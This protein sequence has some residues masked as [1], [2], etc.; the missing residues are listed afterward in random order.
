MKI[1]GQY[2]MEEIEKVFNSINDL[3]NYKIDSELY[4]YFLHDIYEKDFWNYVQNIDPKLCNEYRDLNSGDDSYEMMH[5]RQKAQQK[6]SEKFH[7]IRDKFY[8]VNG[9]IYSYKYIGEY[10]IGHVIEITEYE[11]KDVHYLLN[12]LA[13]DMNEQKNRNLLQRILNK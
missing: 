4:G 9:Q 6:Y 13:S 7:E 11:I 10:N 3:K 1:I 2:E 12:S 5:I 8:L